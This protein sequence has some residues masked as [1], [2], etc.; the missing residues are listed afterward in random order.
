MNPERVVGLN[1]QINLIEVLSLLCTAAQVNEL[2]AEFL[3]PPHYCRF[4]SHVN[5]SESRE[6]PIAVGHT[7]QVKGDKRVGMVPGE[8]II[9]NKNLISRV[10]LSFCFEGEGGSVRHGGEFI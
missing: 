9:S 10:F 7:P 2:Q 3:P 5:V 6:I 4:L 8:I 1:P